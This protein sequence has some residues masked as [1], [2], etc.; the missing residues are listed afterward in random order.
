MQD[1]L[2][3]ILA[4]QR[5]QAR[6]REQR[7]A[8]LASQRCEIPSQLF[9]E[10]NHLPQ[11]PW[12]WYRDQLVVLQPTLDTSLPNQFGGT[13][14]ASWT[15]LSKGCKPHLVL[16]LN[17][18]T[19]PFPLPRGSPVFQRLPLY[20][21]LKASDGPEMLYR[22]ESNGLL[23]ATKS[24]AAKR[25]DRDWPY[26]DYPAFLPPRG[27]AIEGPFPVP[28]VALF[29]LGGDRVFSVQDLP[30]DADKFLIVFVQA[31]EAGLGVSLLGPDA[32]SE[33][34]QIVFFINPETGTVWTYNQ[35]G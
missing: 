15:G 20:H 11:F 23:V 3:K 24:P 7:R 8:L 2:E 29:P 21:P 33:G 32:E 5:E 14:N 26:P 22:A 16:D 25:A 28:F 19:L 6:I 17:P 31:C 35:C 12:A 18:A 10:G 13:R 1:P 30:E 9:V 4:W 34:A 27:L